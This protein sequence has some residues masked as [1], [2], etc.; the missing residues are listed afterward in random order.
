[1]NIKRKLKLSGIFLGVLFL[2]LLIQ[3]FIDNNGVQGVFNKTVRG[4][5]S[6]H[7]QIKAVFKDEEKLVD[8]SQRLTYKNTA[9]KELNYLY[10]H[11]Y[12]NAFMDKSKVPFEEEELDNVYYN[13]FN[14]GW[15][16]INEVKL[17]NKRVDYKV[18]GD[19]STVLRISP[20]TAVK[21]GEAV[22]IYIGFKVQLPNVIGRMGYGDNTVNITNWYPI[23]AVFN[24]EG[25]HLDPYFPIGDPFYSEVASYE[26]TFEIPMDYVLATTGNITKKQ[27]KKNRVIYSINA[28][29]V[30]DFALILSKDFQLASAEA[31]GIAINAYTLKGQRSDLALQYGVDAMKI[32]NELFGVYPYQQLSVVASDFFLG[33]MEYPNLVMI[34][35][36]LYTMKEEFPLEYVIAHEIAH[37]WWYGIVG[38]NEIKEPWLDEALTEYATL[39]YFEKKYGAHIKEQI[40]EKMIKAQYNNY[41]NFEADRGEGILRSLREF[42][43][44]MEYS[45]IV[46]SKGAMFVEVLRREMGEADFIEALREYYQSF[47]FKNATTLDFYEICQKHSKEDLKAVFIEWLNISFE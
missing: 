2:S 35:E 22:E 40:F 16:K 5:E 33:G 4:V 28:E 8:G 20:T 31:D 36:G 6:A 30:R 47:M 12:P 45:S 18:M 11:I 21:T 23:M 17:N 13:G 19:A 46:Y 3:S 38:N 24:E 44:S 37:Q 10:L 27:E 42:D 39:M 25:W 29:N 15:I 7:Y 14:P 9:D 32:F 26:V 1:M 43:S 34:S 41:I